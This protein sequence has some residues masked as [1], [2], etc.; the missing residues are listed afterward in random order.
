[1]LLLGVTFNPTHWTV[2]VA[3]YTTML[4]AWIIFGA[5]TYGTYMIMVERDEPNDKQ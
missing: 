3:F 5:L 4:G 1:M 2:A